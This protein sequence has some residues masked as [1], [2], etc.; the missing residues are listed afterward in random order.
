MSWRRFK[1]LIAGLSLDSR[2]VLEARLDADRPIV[3]DDPAAAEAYF[4][5]IA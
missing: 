5:S 2:W 4:A 1:N 3:L